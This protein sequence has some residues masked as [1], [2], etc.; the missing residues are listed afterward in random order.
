MNKSLKAAPLTANV[1]E[2]N[3]PEEF[4]QLIMAYSK[5]NKN[6][7]AAI[8]EVKTKLE[9][10]D[11]DFQLLHKH[12]PIHHMDSRV[13]SP[14]SIFEKVIRKGYDRDPEKLQK[15]LLDIAGI[16]VICHYVEDI[17]TIAELLKKQ[18]DISI[19]KEVDYIKD[20]KPNGYRSL[21]L[22]VQIP[23]YFVDRVENIPVEVQIR[24]IAM[25]FWASLEHELRYKA[26]GEIPKFIADEL[27]EC[28]DNIA[29]SDIQMQK[30]HSFLE[31]LDKFSPK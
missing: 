29:N 26:E 31:D 24:T 18:D 20:P 10:L 4:K 12:N 25:D 22:V 17:Y 13:K 11:D 7:T 28:S 27:K 9:N 16:R 23:V 2:I 3:N 14:E 19:V 1:F 30:I 8:R 6:Y 5:I 21:H 15:Q